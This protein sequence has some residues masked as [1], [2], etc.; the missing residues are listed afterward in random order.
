M[1]EN[2]TKGGSGPRAGCAAFKDD[3]PAGEVVA[4]RDRTLSAAAG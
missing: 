4:V 1:I 2:G 3:N